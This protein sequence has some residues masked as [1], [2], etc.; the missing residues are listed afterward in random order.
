VTS[1]RFIIYAGLT[2][3]VAIIFSVV[4]TFYKYRDAA[5]AEGR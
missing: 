1:G 4:A 3:V 5:A 2:F